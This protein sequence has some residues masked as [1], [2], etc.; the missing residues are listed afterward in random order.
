MSDSESQSLHV[1]ILAAGA[2]TR[3]GQPKQLVKLKGQPILHKVVSS[4][5]G[6]AGQSVTV[7]LGANAQDLT[8]LLA[9]SSVSVIVNR[10]WQE[11]LASSLRFGLAAAPPACS[12]AL[13]LLGDQWAVTAA[14]LKRLID[15]WNG[16]DSTIAASVYEGHVG[17]P[18][19][20]PRWSFTELRELR[21][22]QGARAILERHAHR[23]SRVQMPNAA[24]D[25]DTPEDLAALTARHDTT[26]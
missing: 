9:R 5:V 3:L 13:I 16:Q 8:P 2:S 24:M 15:A 22:D 26:P 20:F 12:A 19:I 4:A 7:V 17:V 18:A 23:L 6:V 25:L 10:H 21:G 11:G 14:D 1:I